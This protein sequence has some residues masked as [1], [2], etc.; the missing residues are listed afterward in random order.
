MA[1]E[2]TAE[3]RATKSG[4]QRRLWYTV[5]IRPDPE[6]AASI[7]E[8]SSERS[9]NGF[10]QTTCFPASRHSRTA[11]AWGAGGPLREMPRRGEEGP[12]VQRRVAAERQPVAQQEHGLEPVRDRAPGRRPHPQLGLRPRF[13]GAPAGHLGQ[14]GM[15]GPGGERRPQEYEPAT[16]PQVADHDLGLPVIWGVG[17]R[18]Q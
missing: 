3:R 15:A 12:G 7:L 2:R 6:L 8:T 17:A 16:P 13:A 5:S 18:H 10:S 14:P 4:S 1:P 11:E 9:A